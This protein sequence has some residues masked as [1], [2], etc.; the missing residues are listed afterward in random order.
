MIDNAADGVRKGNLRSV[1][2]IS[3]MARILLTLAL[4]SHLSIS[5]ERRQQVHLTLCCDF[6][7][8]FGNVQ[9]II[10]GAVSDF[11]SGEY[12]LIFIDQPKHIRVLRS[13]P[14]ASGAMKRERLG[15]IAKGTF[16]PTPELEGA[17][18]AEEKDELSKA[19]EVYR[20]TQVVQKQAIALSVPET[21]RI[22]VDYV[23]SDATESEKKIIVFALMEAMRLIRKA[24]KQ[25]AEQGI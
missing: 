16:E 10:L 4:L 7:R 12:M 23:Q 24:A 22:A 25:E 5:Y 1:V 20:H 8:W 11:Y 19:I 17:V 13:F 21:M 2:G 9:S 6:R 15:L 18:L 3:R 14:D